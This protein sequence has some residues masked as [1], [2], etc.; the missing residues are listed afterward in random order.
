MCSTGEAAG[1]LLEAVGVVAAEELQHR[2][3]LLKHGLGLL[4]GTPADPAIVIVDHAAI[5]NRQLVAG[6][7]VADNQVAVIIPSAACAGHTH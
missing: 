7:G 2:L 5:G 6:T 1:G 3:R 4:A